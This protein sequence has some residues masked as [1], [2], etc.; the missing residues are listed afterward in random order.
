MGS[1]N[2]QREVIKRQC[3]Y[4]SNRIMRSIEYCQYAQNSSS[5]F[6]SSEIRPYS[7]P[8]KFFQCFSASFFQFL[9]QF[10]LSVLIKLILPKRLHLKQ[11]ICTTMRKLNLQVVLPHR[12]FTIFWY[13]IL[14][15]FLLFLL[16][17]PSFL[18]Y[19][20]I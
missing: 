15:R 9:L 5:R 20:R 19:S 18:I 7:A 14:L 13:D 4:F 17:V 8:L 16:T 10:Y 12:S 2:H 11:N 6:L 1:S 3:F